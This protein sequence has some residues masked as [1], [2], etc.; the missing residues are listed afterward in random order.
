MDDNHQPKESIAIRLIK[1]ASIV[2][3]A[4]VLSGLLYGYADY[5]RQF[6]ERSKLK[7]EIARER[8]EEDSLPSANRR[9]FMGAGVGTALGLAY[10]VRCAMRRK[11]L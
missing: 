4:A 2:F 9:F 1:A 5:W 10:L 3:V 11:K 8:L 7:R 6:T